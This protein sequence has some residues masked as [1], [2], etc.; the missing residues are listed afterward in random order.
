MAYMDL[1]NFKAINDNFG[2][3][4]GDEALT[5]TAGLLKEG[6]RSTDTIARMGGD[7]FVIML[8]EGEPEGSALVL[9]KLRATFLDAM[10]ENGWPVTVSI[11]M[12]T[13]MSTPDSVDDMLKEAD[14]LMYSVKSEGKDNVKLK[15]LD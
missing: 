11:G 13:F 2:H 4:A 6:L 8:P 3:D 12:V 1:D 14:A 5:L 10:K 9:F 7:E 15:V